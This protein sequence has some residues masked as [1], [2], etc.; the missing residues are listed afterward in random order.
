MGLFATKYALL[1]LST[2][3]GGLLTVQVTNLIHGCGGLAREI[4]RNGTNCCGFEVVATKKR[5]LFDRK[6]NSLVIVA[7][8]EEIMCKN[9]EFTTPRIYYGFEIM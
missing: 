2:V 4:I 5:L 8:N 7:P 3:C 6:A 9:Y 1:H